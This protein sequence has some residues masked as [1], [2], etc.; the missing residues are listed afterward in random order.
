MEF[1]RSS[2]IWAVKHDPV[3]KILTVWFNDGAR[4]YDYFGVPTSV[5]QGLLTANSAGRY[6][7]AYIRD[8]YAA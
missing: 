2:A 8:Q 5:Y 7:K 4:S 3:S 6:F 1:I